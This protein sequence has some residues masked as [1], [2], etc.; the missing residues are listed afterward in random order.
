MST[1]RVDVVRLGEIA[2]HPNADSLG[3]VKVLGGYTCVVR[4]SDW[5][6]GDLAAYIPPDSVVDTTRPEFSFLGDKSKIRVR[7][8]R[9]VYSMGLLIPAPQGASEGDD[10]A[11]SLGVTH[12]Q[13][14]A[15]FSVSGDAIAAP[16]IIAPK[17]DVENLLR[18][19]NVFREGEELVA[20]EKIHGANCRMTIVDGQMFVGSRNLWLREDAK[21]IYWQAFRSLPQ[22][23]FL[24][25]GKKQHEPVNR[26]LYGEVFGRVQDLRYG[27][28]NSV[29]FAAFDLLQDGVFV[30]FHEFRTLMDNYLVPSAPAVWR[31]VYEGE[32]TMAEWAELIECDSTVA[33]APPGHIREGIVIRP[34]VE[35]Y[36]DTLGRVQLKLVSNRYFEH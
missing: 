20:T 33:G 3:I 13:P 35:R 2:K 12:Y 17:Y 16:M 4:L 29:S 28:D 32:K 24:L 25:R 11:E 1:F 21:N 30:G 9:G 23:E 22:I 18:F 31:G 5:H 34:T 36:D 19:A 14:P 27:R 6:E 10:V 26:V 15:E 8:L 7:R